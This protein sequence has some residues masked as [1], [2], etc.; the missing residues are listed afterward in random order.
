MARRLQSLFRQHV[1]VDYRPEMLGD[2]TYKFRVP[3]VKGEVTTPRELR[4]IKP[5]NLTQTDTTRIIDHGELWIKRVN[6][7]LNLNVEPTCL[8][9][10]VKTAAENKRADVS[11]DICEQFKALGVRTLEFGHQDEILGFA[12]AG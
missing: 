4:L 10:P 11:R 1:I 7:L 2:E 12:K 6:R 9:L 3:F 5:L 8:L